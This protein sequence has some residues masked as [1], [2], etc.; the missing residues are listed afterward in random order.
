MPI[1][2]K[3]GHLER[4][5]DN[6]IDILTHDWLNSFTNNFGVNWKLHEFQQKALKNAMVVLFYY[7]HQDKELHREL[8]RH[9][10]D[11]SQKDK[12]NIN[13]SFESYKTNITRE[14]QK[15]FEFTPIIAN[16]IH[17]LFLIK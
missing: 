13:K 4:F 14:L 3:I 12:D 7:F 9:F 6:N 1:E 17:P 10:K 11:L 16:E 5:A 15:D 2:N 8:Y